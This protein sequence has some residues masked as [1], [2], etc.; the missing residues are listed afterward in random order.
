[1]TTYDQSPFDLFH[2]LGDAL[3]LRILCMVQVQELCFCDL[4]EILKVPESRLVRQLVL[5]RQ[6]GLIAKRK[7]GNYVFY[8]IRSAANDPLWQMTSVMLPALGTRWTSTREDA[9]AA[10]SKKRPACPPSHFELKTA[11]K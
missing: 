10:K 9:A 2:M 3:R 6:A 11:K 8:K 1:M 4:L 7:E 5:L